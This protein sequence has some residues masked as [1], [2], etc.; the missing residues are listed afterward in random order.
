MSKI[1]II[2]CVDLTAESA[3][4]YIEAAKGLIEPTR[5][6]PGCDYYGMAVDISDPTKLWISE[7]WSSQEALNAHLKTQH[8]QDFIAYS[9]TLDIKGMDARQYEV[10][11]VGP[12]VIPE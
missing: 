5:A 7:E 11:S 6:E 2:A 8:I 1:A 12:V 4:L 10:S 9:A 3:P